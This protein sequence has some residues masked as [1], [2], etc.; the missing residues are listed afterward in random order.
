MVRNLSAGMNT[1]RWT[2]THNG[3]T[4][5]DEVTVDFVKDPIADIGV[6]F[7][8]GCAPLTVTFSNRTIG[9]AHYIWEFDDGTIE[10]SFNPRPR[11]F[12][13]GLHTVRLIAIGEFKT[14]TATVVIDVMNYPEIVFNLTDT[15]FLPNER[16]QFA[17]STTGA[18]YY[19]WDFGNN[20]TSTEPV[21]AHF[22]EEEGLYHVN[23]F[24]TNRLG[25]ERDSTINILIIDY[26]KNNFIVF[27]NAF[28]PNI[29]SSNG[30]IYDLDLRKTDVF[31]PIWNGVNKT[32][33]YSLEIFN[34]WGQM[35]FQTNDL[36]RGWDGYSNGKLAPQGTYIYR[37]T[38]TFMNGRLFTRTGEVNLIH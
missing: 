1:F 33:P 23:L 4:A 11:T 15:L 34:R 16:I 20:A 17:N 27:P 26:T 29:A 21:P 18:D 9:I 36:D 22:Y 35:I 3:C 8:E 10:T 25:C 31:Y 2:V 38:G 24:V 28:T 14:D 6:D 12:D 5:Y 19:L 30:G 13:A 32:R 37:A 7:R